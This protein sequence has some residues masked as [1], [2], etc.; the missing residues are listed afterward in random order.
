MLPYFHVSVYLHDYWAW[1]LIFSPLCDDLDHVSTYRLK[2]SDHT[3]H[4]DQLTL[5]DQIDHHDHPSWSNDLSKY[6]R[7]IHILICSIHDIF[8]S[9]DIHKYFS[10]LFLPVNMV[11]PVLDIYLH[12]CRFLCWVPRAVV[13]EEIKL[14]DALALIFF[15]QKIVFS[16]HQIV[17]EPISPR[18]ELFLPSP[19]RCR[20]Y[21]GWGNCPDSLAFSVSTG[22]D[23]SGS[24]L[25]SPDDHEGNAS[26]GYFPHAPHDHDCHVLECNEPHDG[27]AYDGISHIH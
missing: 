18:I 26:D 5:P 24:C 10:K 27:Q 12:C 8:Q 23:G 3:D 20:R 13:K 14:A 21:Q 16:F 15:T 1:H 6:R 19:W 2:A 11:K 17:R 9:V 4:P 7:L 25:L 22:Q